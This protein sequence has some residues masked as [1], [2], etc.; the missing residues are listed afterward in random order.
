[1][2]FAL[3]LLLASLLP[4]AQ[5]LLQKSDLFE[6]KQNG[7]NLYRIPGIVVTRKGTILAYAEARQANR[8]DWGP[9][10]IVLR[11]STDNGKTW[12][13]QRV[14]ANVEGPHQKNPVAL[15][16]NLAQPTDKTYN[17]PVAIPD[18][19]GTVHFLFCLEYM[20]A[21]YMRSTDDGKTFSKPIE[22][23]AA[24]EEFRKDYNWKVLA[25]GPGHGIQLRNG[26][27]L[28]PIWISLG[29]GGHAH[30]PSVASVIYS[31]D[32]GQSWHR[33]DIAVPDTPDF[34]YPSET[35]AA[36]LPD[37]RV[38]LNARSEAKARRR[39]LTYSMDGVTNWSKPAFHEQLREPVCMASMIATRYGLIFSNPDTPGPERRNV[40]IRLSRDNG[41]TWPVAKPLEPGP[42]GYSDLAPA[43]NGDILC[44]YERANRYLTLARFN[45]A[46]LQ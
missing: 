43:R 36:Q 9:I 26:R 35:M 29:T 24:F 3:F 17:N 7:Y 14:I 34:V 13:P 27:L 23:T 11:R 30:R 39:I 44:F 21:F 16:Q 33:G 46:W 32:H 25:T 45:L 8:G 6:A 12:E 40:T 20:R 2:R 38:L 18:R 10:D 37:G 4:A 31:D 41:Q 42:S 1:M 5:P 19:D 28:V 22:I 15:A